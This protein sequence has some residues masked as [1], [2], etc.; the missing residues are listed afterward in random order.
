MACECSFLICDQCLHWSEDSNPTEVEAVEQFFF[1]LELR[2]VATAKSS[3]LIEDVNDVPLLAIFVVLD[4]IKLTYFI[5]A[6][7]QAA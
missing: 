6:I 2:D 1:V 4:E 7:C 5:E 3:G